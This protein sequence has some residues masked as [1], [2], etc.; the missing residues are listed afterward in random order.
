MPNTLDENWVIIN[1]FVGYLNGE[2]DPP[3][4]PGLSEE[5][6]EYLKTP[7]CRTRLKSWSKVMIP[8]VDAIRVA[9][10][11]PKA[12]AKEESDFLQASVTVVET[13]VEYVN[14]LEDNRPTTN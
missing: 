12:R 9:I 5:A 10:I 6:V 4:I 3:E 2:T 7:E 13:I 1:T 11:N 8:A 14:R